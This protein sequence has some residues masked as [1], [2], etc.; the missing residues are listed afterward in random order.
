MLFRSQ[1]DPLV[2]YT[3][4]DGLPA[5]TLSLQDTSLPTAPG[6]YFIS[7]F[8]NDSYT[9]VS[10]RC[11]FTVV[12]TNITTN[13]PVIDGNKPVKIF[14]NPGNGKITSIECVYPIEKI[15][16]LNSSGQTVFRS[17]N[18]NDDHFTLLNQQLPNGIYF[19]K[20]YTRMTYTLKLIIEN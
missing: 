14:P 8:T 2:S 6:S 19:I 5:G 7:L 20:I 13:V 12:D 9:E 17:R 3:Y 16:L 10:N 15:E 18:I 1:V 11:Y 4:F